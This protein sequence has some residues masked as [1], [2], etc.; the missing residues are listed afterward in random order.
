MIAERPDDD[1]AMLVL[2]KLYDRD[3][4]WDRSI[5]LR[6]RAVAQAA[7]PEA[8]AQIWI[9]VAL[10]EEKRG[11]RDAALAALDR[12]IDTGVRRAEILREQARIHRQAGHQAK[13]LELVR[14]ELATEPPLARRMQL[15]REQAQLLI[16]LDLEPEAV[17]AAYLD[18]LSIEP[19]QSE[20]LDGIEG[21][22]RKLGLWDELARAFRGAPATPRNLE[23][24]G[25]ALAKIAEWT[26]LAE[27]RR[28]QLEASTTAEEK[29]R[30]AALGGDGAGARTRAPDQPRQRAPRSRHSARA[31]RAA[32]RQARARAGGGPGVRGRARA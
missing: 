5:E 24:L 21:P 19:D 26:E 16:A 22:A 12:A 30:R 29:A 25:E 4:Q 6:K 13:A 31:R 23:V 3:Q 8:R 10:R 15:Q 11:D 20:A 27:V 18:V 32:R 14:A 9:D 1:D 2:A 17:V 28:R 7:E